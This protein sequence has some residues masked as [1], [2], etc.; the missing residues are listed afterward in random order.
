MT[1][2]AVDPRHRVEVPLGQRSYDILIG[3]GLI[4]D[5]GRRIVRLG[6]ARCAA[7]VTDETVAERHL[8]R[9]RA[10]LETAGLRVPVEAVPAGEHS[11]RLPMLEQ[12][13]DALLAARV[14]RGDI[15]V[16]FGGGV[17]GDLAG[18]AAGILRRGVRLVQIPTTL[19]AQVDS[20]VG[21]K[22]GVNTRHGKN[23]VGLFHQ[24]A[25]VIA[26]TALLD[27]LPVREFR[28][29][30]AEV[31]KYGLLGDATFFASL[32]KSWPEVFAGG[33]ARDS[34][35]ERSCAMK[36]AIVARDETESGER[37][38]LNLGHT[39]A[40]AL[41][42]ATGFGP[43]LLHGEAVAIG[44]RLAFA[45]SAR[46]GLVPLDEVARVQHHLAAV[47]L[48]TRTGEIEGSVLSAETLLGH[49]AQD[50]KVK[51]GALTFILVRGIGQAFV[52]PD[53]PPDIV[54][55]FLEDELRRS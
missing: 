17:V 1:S 19:L 45:F 15:I 26:D 29:G 35:I 33:P 44:L 9:L 39:F 40:H 48:P 22:T 10:S 13:L 54:R 30:Y 51:D 52:A 16:A 36:A 46:L 21:G 6:G 43:R 11:K 2:L 12:V 24:P 47:G 25:L 34:A 20:S 14:E 5:A 18:F 53:V 4:D 37:A 55:A 7:V 50:K 41:E 32:E 49:I 31:A 8:P 3:A 38:L 28:A 42:A 27:T 23:L